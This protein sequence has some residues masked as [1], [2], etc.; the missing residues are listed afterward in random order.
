VGPLFGAIAH[1]DGECGAKLFVERIISWI[2]MAKGQIQ[3]KQYSAI[4]A[5]SNRL[6]AQTK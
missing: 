5:I 3:R 4:F 1:H 2:T 6:G